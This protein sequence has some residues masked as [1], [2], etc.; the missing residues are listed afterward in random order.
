MHVEFLSHWS[1]NLSRE[2]YVNR[3]GHA[4]MP[5]IVFASSGGSHNEYADFGM[6]EACSWFIETGKIQFF[7]L[8]SVDSESWLA[9]WKSPHDR[10]EMHRA[11]ERYVIEEAIPFIKHKTGWFDPMM[12]IGCSMGAYHAV[13]FFLQHPD[14]FNKDC[15]ERSL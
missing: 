12:T 10:A 15:T 2:M 8:S 13:N 5:V 6:I 7:T 11:Y 9:D 14:V 1:G 3:Y 4:G